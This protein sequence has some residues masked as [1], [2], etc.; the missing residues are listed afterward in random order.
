MKGDLEM[1]KLTGKK[2][3]ITNE[4]STWFDEWGIVK[5]NDDEYYHIAPAGDEN[6]LLAFYPDEFKVCRK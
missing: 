4:E 3:I 1:K 6:M 5:G 2:V